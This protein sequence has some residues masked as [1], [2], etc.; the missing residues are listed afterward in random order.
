MT[1]EEILPHLRSGKYI[2]RTSW[3]VSWSKFQE[4]YWYER[5]KYDPPILQSLFGSKLRAEDLEATDWEI[6]ERKNS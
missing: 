5:P 1:F 2:W 4:H 6:Y 3:F